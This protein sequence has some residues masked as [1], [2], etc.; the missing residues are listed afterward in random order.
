MTTHDKKIVSR[1][2]T[3]IGQN[4]V[5]LVLT[6]APIIY[7]SLPIGRLPQ[8][9][10][11]LTIVIGA[12]LGGC[13]FV[14]AK[15]IGDSIWTMIVLY[16]E[17]A[18][19]VPSPGDED[20]AQKLKEYEKWANEIRN[21]TLMQVARRAFKRA[22]K[23]SICVTFPLMVIA[24]IMSL[25]FGDSEFDVQIIG[26]LLVSFVISTLVLIAILTGAIVGLSTLM[27][28]LYYNEHHTPE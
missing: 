14:P 17:R 3:K 16:A 18:V 22:L 20:Y 23:G 12:F 26:I 5:R 2:F 15:E 27:L 28:K 4:I 21:A 19:G 8:P 9:P 6:G 11:W 13:V 24:L 25:L 7:L 1:E 10:L